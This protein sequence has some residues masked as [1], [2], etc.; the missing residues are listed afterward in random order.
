[1][2][3]V[4]SF[5]NKKKSYHLNREQGTGVLFAEWCLIEVKKNETRIFR[6][7]D[8]KILLIGLKQE[9]TKRF[10]IANKD[11]LMKLNRNGLVVIWSFNDVKMVEISGK[12]INYFF[13]E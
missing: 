11:F 9:I 10:E 7:E 6:K 2:F 1:M 12:A 4:C 5:L 8:L 13:M 3:G